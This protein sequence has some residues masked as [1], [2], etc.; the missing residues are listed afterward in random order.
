M[1]IQCDVCEKA[2]ASVICCADEAALCTECDIE[3]HEANKLASKHQRLHLHFISN[4]LPRCDICQEKPA[5][6]FCV[7]DRALFCR[8]CDEPIHTTGSLSGNHQRFLATGIRVA[9]ASASKDTSVPIVPEPPSRN[10]QKVAEK[11]LQVHAPSAYASPSWPDDE[12]LQLSDFDANDKRE[13][14]G[15]GGLDWMEDIGLFN[16]DVP[17]ESFGAAQVPEISNFNNARPPTSKSLVSLKK[18]R[19]EIPQQEEDYF[20]VPDLGDIHT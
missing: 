17:H 15:F 16:E 11:E 12:L 18:P 9:L 5:F 7:E 8:D 3:V 20:T 6:I 1:K 10:S 13:C 14:I 19:L 2:C 4:Q